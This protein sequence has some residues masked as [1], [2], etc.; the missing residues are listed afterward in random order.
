VNN[1]FAACFADEEPINVF[2]NLHQSAIPQ[3]GI[4]KCRLVY[5]Q[6]VHL[7]EFVP[8]ERRE[9][10]TL[11]LVETDLESFD[12]KNED[13]TGLNAAFAKRD[14]C[15]DVL[16]IKNGLLTDTSYCNIAI[17]D[18]KNWFTPRIPLLYGV[19]RAELLSNVKL[20]EK[21]ISVGDLKNYRQIA[22]FNAMIEFGELVL[23]VDCLK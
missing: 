23:D 2:E 18:G 11:K 15:D 12:Y 22:L 9:I 17:S 10:R 1:A 16:L 8:Y 20:V 4:F 3:N 14:G 21:D 6:D 5:S 13:R 19:N 7:L